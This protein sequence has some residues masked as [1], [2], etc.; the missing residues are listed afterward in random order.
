MNGFS[1]VSPPSNSSAKSLL[2]Q[3]CRY[4]LATV[5]LSAAATKL[6]DLPHF[7][8]QI[9]LHTDAVLPLVVARVI[10]AFIPW[11]ELTCGFCLL[12]DVARR[13][14]AAVL[15]VLLIAFTVYVFLKPAQ[16]D[17]GCFF[18][19]RSI[20]VPVGR[21]WPIVRN[22]LLLL[23]AMRV[24]WRPVGG[25]TRAGTPGKMSASHPHQEIP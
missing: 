17:C 9:I 14:A 21:W 22:L 12:L 24:A 11:L 19:P 15:G 3:L 13:E 6:L 20:P 10:A 16:A 7:A 4:V 8:D 1:P 25:S 2:D 18:L 23:C 5:F